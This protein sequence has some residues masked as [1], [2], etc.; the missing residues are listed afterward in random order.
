VTKGHLVSDLNK[1]K[2]NCTSDRYSS[3]RTL[4]QLH[5]THIHYS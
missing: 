5:L 4:L 1:K 3:F 2:I